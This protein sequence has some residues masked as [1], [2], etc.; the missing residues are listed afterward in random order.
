MKR[1]F[2][3]VSNMRFV[4]WMIIC[5]IVF[6][7]TVCGFISGILEGENAL[8]RVGIFVPL[9]I[10]AIFYLIACHILDEKDAERSKQARSIK[11]H[12]I[13]EKYATLGIRSYEEYLNKATDYYMSDLFGRDMNIGI[14]RAIIDFVESEGQKVNLYSLHL[15]SGYISDHWEDY[16][17]KEF[18]FC[19]FAH[20]YHGL[21]MT[22][23]THKAFSYRYDTSKLE[24][25]KCINKK[26]IN[27][28][29]YMLQSLS[30]QMENRE[31]S[32]EEFDISFRVPDDF[33]WHILPDYD[34]IGIFVK[35][36]GLLT[37]DKFSHH[38]ILQK[39]K[40]EEVSYYKYIADLHK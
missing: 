29:N 26:F 16:E 17:N 21:S 3:T 27:N 28:N 14:S 12:Q 7:A 8:T 24:S 31:F 5:G 11:N 6:G 19:C 1:F 38:L 39:C 37:K 2:D 25:V 23:L 9:I 33:D 35:A 10:V 18:S 20:P 13:H 22:P 4:E 40:L 30:I 15:F 34:N 32:N 36:T